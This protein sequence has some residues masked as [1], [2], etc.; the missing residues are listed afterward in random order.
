MYVMSFLKSIFTGGGRQGAGSAELA[1]RRLLVDSWRHTFCRVE[2]NLVAA[3]SEA[4]SGMEEV[5]AASFEIYP[6]G[7]RDEIRVVANVKISAS[8]LVPKTAVPTQKTAQKPGGT[9]G[10]KNPA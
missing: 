4:L 2:K 6:G 7:R 3:V 5:D 10:E 8:F 1:K 9:R